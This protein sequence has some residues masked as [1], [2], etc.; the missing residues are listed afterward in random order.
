[1]TQ[2]T[3]HGTIGCTRARHAAK[4]DGAGAG[5]MVSLMV[6]VPRVGT[7]AEDRTAACKASGGLRL[8]RRSYSPNSGSND[9]RAR[10]RVSK[11]LPPLV[12]STRIPV[13]LPSRHCG[14]GSAQ[15]L[16]GP[17]ASP[18]KYTK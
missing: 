4:R 9:T 12:Y 5:T 17:D 15:K 14:V 16:I 2:A 7:L 6:R 13:L 11:S 1:M 18:V 10:T 8:A 3:S